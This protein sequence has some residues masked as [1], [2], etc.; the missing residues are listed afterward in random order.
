MKKARDVTFH[1]FPHLLPLFD[2]L[3]FN[4]T[5]CWYRKSDGSRNFI[6]RQEGSSQGCPFAA[7]LAGLVLHDV[8]DTIN[9]ELAQRA[10]DRKSQNKDSDDGQGTRALIMSYI[11]D[12]TVSIVTYAGDRCQ[13]NTLIGCVGVGGLLL[14]DTKL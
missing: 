9:S 10:T 14:V 5:K 13:Q 11:G 4:N 6:W 8:I 7:F 12:T 3:Y 2:I 1:K